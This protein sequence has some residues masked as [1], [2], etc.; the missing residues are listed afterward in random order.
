M[1]TLWDCPY[2][3]DKTK[4]F[5]QKEI[6]FHQTKLEILQSN[7]EVDVSS[8]VHHTVAISLIKRI[9]SNLETSCGG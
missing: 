1:N 5:L 6:E 2:C 8:I 4:E 3:K 7:W 9:L